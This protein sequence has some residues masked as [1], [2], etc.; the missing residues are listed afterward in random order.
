MPITLSC[1]TC[2]KR[3]RARDESAGKRVKCP[4]CQAAIVV[5]AD[6]T[7]AESPAD[8][9]PTR[10]PPP[11]PSARPASSPVTPGDWS[12]EP[13]PG[14]GPKS[15]PLPPPP[16]AP[17]RGYGVAPPVPAP[18]PPKTAGLPTT[19]ATKEKEPAAPRDAKTPGQLVLPAWKKTKAGLFW[20]LAGLFFLAL[21]GFFE[22][23]KL[24]YERSV[25]ELPSGDGWIKIDGVV[26]AGKETITLTKGQEIEVLAYGVPIVLG[27]LLLTLGR[28]AAGAAP[29]A[30]G[31]KGL[32]AFSGLFTLLGLASLGV[33]AVTTAVTMLDIARYTAV[34]VLVAWGLAEVWFITGL[35]TTGAHLKRPSVARSVG[36][37]WFVLALGVALATVG[38][39]QYTK[40]LRPKPNAGI[41][42]LNPTVTVKV[43]SL[44]IHE[45][46]RANAVDKDTELYEAGARML[47]WLV[48]VGCYWRAVRSTRVAIRE[49]ID[50]VEE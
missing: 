25:G 50:G 43:R 44:V 42:D 19:K 37:L 2:G 17:V 9:A 5:N 21:P 46:P 8:P 33:C 32:F 28:L 23:G 45:S 48:V 7:A 40:E 16:A 18:R 22:F 15:A 35:A 3:F 4:Y 29:R 34:G 49:F 10:F 14:G 24:V 39:E 38:W 20:V 6:G 27:M 1:P 47:G 11:G 30:S 26:N 41:L 36:F 13:P 12:D 31:A